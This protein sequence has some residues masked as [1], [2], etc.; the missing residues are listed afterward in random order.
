VTITPYFQTENVTLYC[1]D[2]LEIL[3]KLGK[4]DAVVTDPPYGMAY[5]SNR[6]ESGPRFNHIAG[7]ETPFVWFLPFVFMASQEPSVLVCFCRWDSAQAF[8]D[9]IGWSGYDVAGQ[10]VW[11][12]EHHGM[13]DLRGAPAPMHDTIW[14]GRKGKWKF[15]GTRG[16]SVLR[17]KRLGGD[18]LQHPTE[19]PLPLMEEICK[20]YSK[21]SSTIL[22]PFMGS[23]TTGVA[24]VKT[25]RKFIGIEIDPHYCEIAKQRI[26]K[27]IEEK[28]GML[29]QGGEK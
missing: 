20:T 4:V 7:D 10:C 21:A 3:P 8:H 1:G 26:V 22:D 25:G 6:S 12:R 14:I 11:D 2:C 16:K 24:C 18:A 27:A 29:L 17:H 5:Q 19:K 23:G 28:A 9:A 13:G 15:P